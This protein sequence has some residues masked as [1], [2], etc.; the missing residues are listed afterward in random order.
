MGVTTLTGSNLFQIERIIHD[1]VAAYTEKYG[2]LSIEKIDAEDSLASEIIAR[3]SAESLFA[4]N[5]LMIIR[6]LE[7]NSELAEAPDK[8]ITAVSD[9]HELILVL[10]KPDKRSRLYAVLKKN[11]QF[12]EVNGRTG[13]DLIDWLIDIVTDL[14]GQID[15]GIAAYIINRIGNDQVALANELSKL[16][17]Y[18]PNIT[19]QT[20]DLLVEMSP[21]STIFQ[22]LSAAF[23]GDK[24]AVERLYNERRFLKDEPQQIIGLIVWQLHILAVIKAS[25]SKPVDEIAHD[26]GANPKSVAVSANLARRLSDTKLNLLITKLLELDNKIKQQAVNA[27]DVLLYFLL[28]I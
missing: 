19:R 23:S 2:E 6:G 17:I 27:D 1:Q 3:V 21:Q 12:K 20:I 9:A 15:R 10:P 18:D 25:K 16:V 7:A 14:G 24:R 8:I 4:S 11:T 5:K 28:S 22:L 13:A 26:L